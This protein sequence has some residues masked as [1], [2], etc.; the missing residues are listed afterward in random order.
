[1]NFKGNIARKLNLN[2]KQ[3]TYSTSKSL[4]NPVAWSS[5][6]H[7]QLTELPEKRKDGQESESS[8]D[9]S[10]PSG[11]KKGKKSHLG[12]KARLF[13]LIKKFMKEE[14]E[15]EDKWFHLSSTF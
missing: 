2:S 4:S 8:G 10:L 11:S 3:S 13:T 12:D 6:S 14:E 7:E 1:M 9:E 15:E 5:I